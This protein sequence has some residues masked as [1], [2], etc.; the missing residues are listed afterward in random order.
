GAGG[1]RPPVVLAV[2]QPLD[3]ALG[4]LVDVSPVGVEEPDLDRVGVAG[5]QPHGDPAPRGAVPHL[6][7]GQRHRGELDV[8]DVGAGEVQ[9]ADDG[10]L[11]RPRGPARVT[12]G[13][14]GGALL[15]RG[16]VCRRDADRHLG[17]HVDVRQPRMPRRPKSVRAPRLSH[18]IDE[19]TMAPFSTVLNGYTLTFGLMTACSPTKHSSPT[20][21]PSSMRA[22]ARRSV[23][24]PIT[25]PRKRALGPTY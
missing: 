16:A 23:E 25:Q 18:T 4:G 19:F 15:E 9:A 5:G 13:G 20:T 12:A 6:E 2:E 7:P 17:G 24:R 11:Q 8:L 10:P 21:T 14:D 1:E 22:W 3:L